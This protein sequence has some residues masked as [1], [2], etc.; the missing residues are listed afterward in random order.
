MHKISLS[1][2]IGILLSG[3]AFYFSLKN[4]PFGVLLNHAASINYGWILPAI[5]ACFADFM[6]SAVRWRMI[7]E[8]AGKINFRTAYHG[9]MIA[10]MVNCIL[11]GRAGEIVRPV[12]LYRQEEVPLSIGL[13]SVIVEGI[14]DIIL[15]LLFFSVFLYFFQIDPDFQMRLGDMQL[16]GATLETVGKSMLKLCL[17]LICGIILISFKKTRNH[18][19]GAIKRIPDFVWFANSD[20]KQKIREK[21]CIPLLN[22]VGNFVTGFSLLKNVEKTCLCV[23]LTVVIW[24]LTA[25]FYYIVAA[26]CLGVSL[27][28]PEAIAVMVIISF[29]ISLPSVP[30]FWG[31]WE[32]GGVF[33][34]SLFGVDVRDAASFALV[35]H[36]VYIFPVILAGLI[37]AILT[38]VRFFR[39]S[40]YV[41]FDT[42]QKGL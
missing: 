38:G 23:L 32:A 31:L 2:V 35:S 21:L 34:M 26:G 30:G 41:S 36:L 17:T 4:I 22:V 1:M 6:L 24:L 33:A 9:T 40:E 16:N 13:A 25:L 11:P 5:A 12:I 8:S 10:L 37:S 7:L 29:F 42:T 18:I 28:F 27:S 15:L 14:F 19:T 3:A 20:L 39:I